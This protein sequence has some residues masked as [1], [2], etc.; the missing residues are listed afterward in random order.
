MDLHKYA[1]T[2][3]TTRKSQYHHGCVVS[4]K[5]RVMSIRTNEI[6][7]L[8]DTTLGSYR[9]LHAEYMA[10]RYLVRM[11]GYD[12]YRLKLDV[13]V[14]RSDLG[15]SKPCS[16]CLQYMR[17]FNIRKVTYS[18]DHKFVTERFGNMYNDHLSH[19]Q[20]KLLQSSVS[21]VHNGN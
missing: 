1:K 5:G 12:I 18:M 20:K 11:I 4:S 15:N 14:I 7:L 16:Q 6:G 10:L 17:K 13:S 8:Y 21:R 9:C 2:L 3:K 19:T